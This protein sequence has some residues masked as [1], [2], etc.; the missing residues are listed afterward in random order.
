MAMSLRVTGGEARGRLVA[1][2]S[3]NQVR[4]TASKVRQSIFNILGEKTIESSFLDLFAG[5]GI[6]GLEALSRGAAKL[7]SVE[8]NP[9]LSRAL[10]K[11][12]DQ[13]S[14]QA[15]LKV[16]DVKTELPRLSNHKFDI[17]YADPPYKSPLIENLVEMVSQANLL[18]EDGVLIIEH[19]NTREALQPQASGKL[20]AT[21][22]RVYGQT[23]VS[24]FKPETK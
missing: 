19:A 24:F 7:V 12:L 13:F 11:T 10:Q 16:G 15:E 6:M 14:F 21:D 9:S 1:S 3:G 8:M 20:V 18:N 17:I 23:S 22:K 5:T 4:P 2:P